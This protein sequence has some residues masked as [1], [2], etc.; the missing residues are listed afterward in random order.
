[1][2]KN[3]TT[4][5]AIVATIHIGNI[6]VEGLRLPDGSF[7]ISI[8]QIWRLFEFSVQPTDASRSI[9]R[10]LGNSFQYSRVY[11]ELNPKKVNAVD[12]KTFE[13]IVAK[14]DR[15]GNKKAQDFRD[16]LVGL[17]LQQ[18][19]CDAFSIK[20]EKEERQQ[21][22]SSRQQGKLTRR[23]LTNA[24]RD[25]INAN[26]DQLSDNYKKFIWNNCT[27]A[28]NRIVFGRSAKK[29]KEDW[30]TT[31][32]RSAMTIEELMINAM[33]IVLN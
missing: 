19:F 22:L 12:L 33:I 10:L 24:I 4:K 32:V 17:S 3:N 30:D 14:L 18:L 25:Y 20:F 11:S 21:W 5:K 28:V 26:T 1:M 9:K 29:L 27:D 7:A 6:E 16:D 13:L 8:P 31:E 23:T 2:S 15:K